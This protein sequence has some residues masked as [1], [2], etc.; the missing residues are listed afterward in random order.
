MTDTERTR[1]PS[2]QSTALLLDLAA[3]L[4]ASAIPADAAEKRLRGVAEAFGLDAQFFTM[5]SFLATELRRGDI[6]RIE[7]R[8]IPFDTHW[9]LAETA[10]LTELCRAIVD[11]RLDVA[12]ARK[13]LDRIVGRKSAYP[14]WL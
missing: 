7:I 1:G 2:D 11:R 6:E 3:A 4:H 12:A 10:A 9:D 13:E 8:L 5:Q 14:R